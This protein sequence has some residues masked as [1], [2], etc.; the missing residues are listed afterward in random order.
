MLKSTSRSEQFYSRTGS[1]STKGSRKGFGLLNE[2][3]CP[4][5]V[6]SDDERAFNEQRAL[7]VQ[8]QAAQMALAEAKVEMKA[9]FGKGDPYFKAQRKK[10]CANQEIQVLTAKLS[11]YKQKRKNYSNSSIEK[12]FMDWCRDNMPQGQFKA[13][14]AIAARKANEEA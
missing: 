3:D 4:T 7:R 13:I 5:T 12:H 1:E 2:G 14:L 8:M 9:N 11:E 6:L 10:E